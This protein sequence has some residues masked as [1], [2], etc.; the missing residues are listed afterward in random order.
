MGTLFGV[1]LEKMFT[2]NLHF[3]EFLHIYDIYKVQ[4]IWWQY[5]WDFKS[6]TFLG[7]S[8]INQALLGV[9]RAWV[10]DPMT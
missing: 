4:I 1:D 7:P 10:L 5:N 3:P 2:R 6:K 9:R 8:L